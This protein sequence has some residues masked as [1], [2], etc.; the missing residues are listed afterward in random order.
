MV[1]GW[2]KKKEIRADVARQRD[3][4]ISEIPEIISDLNQSQISQTVTKIRRLRDSTTPLIDEIRRIG[5]VL[6]RDS[7]NVDDIDKHLAVIVIRGKRQVIDVIKKDVVQLPEISSMDDAKRLDSFLSQIL[8]KVGYVLGRQTR[9]IHI[10]AKK[11]AGQ[12]K[13]NLAIMNENQSTIQRLLKKYDSARSALSEITDLLGQIETL[14]EEMV[15][16][17]QRIRDVNQTVKSLDAEITSMQNAVRELKSSNDYKRYVKLKDV[18]DASSIKISGIKN[19][20]DAQFTKISRPLGRYEYGSSLDKEQRDILSRLVREP[21]DVI[22]PQNIDSIIIIL[23]N[24]RK[25]ISSGS[26]SVK[27]VNKSLSQITET[28][29]A[30]DGFVRRI[31]EYS[32]RQETMR[33]DLDSLSSD[34]LASLE[35]G[36]DKNVSLKQ[37]AQFKLETLQAETNEIDSEIPELYSEIEERL[38]RVSDI[39]YTV[40]PPLS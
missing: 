34:E 23:E 37:D 20:I 29:E 16:K 32:K 19:E 25:G 18:L 26:I 39:R 36:M 13:E 12:L 17:S 15:V 11:Y 30:L 28:E 21:F 31:S 9:V 2:G 24:V 5:D 10:F 14:K 27:D 38:G 1:F 22:L 8:K 40:L 7:L 6:A 33:D 35:Q 3:V 4:Q